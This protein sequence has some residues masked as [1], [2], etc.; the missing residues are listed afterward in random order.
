MSKEQKAGAEPEPKI[1]ATLAS[2]VIS[3][4]ILIVACLGLVIWSVSLAYGTGE[5]TDGQLVVP[6]QA[7]YHG[8]YCAYLHGAVRV[9]DQAWGLVAP[10]IGG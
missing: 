10:W 2:R 5:G 4:I 8:P 3:L 6:A 9:G 1:R 7:G